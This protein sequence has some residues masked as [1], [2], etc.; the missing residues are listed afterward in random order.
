ML[1]LPNNMNS[2]VFGS[3]VECAGSI[4]LGVAVHIAS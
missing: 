3:G 4:L 2:I 1:V